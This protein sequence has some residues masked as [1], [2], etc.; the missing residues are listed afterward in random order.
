MKISNIMNIRHL[1]YFYDSAQFLSMS[2]AAKKNFVGQPAISKAIKS[3]EFDLGVTLVE[4]QNNRFNLTDEGLKAYQS[5]QKIFQSIDEFKDSLSEQNKYVGEVKFACQSS[6]AESQF[7]LN[8]IS[9]LEKQYPD[10]NPNLMLG[11]TDLVEKW[12]NEGIIDFG[13]VI[14]NRNF[15]NYKVF[16]VS[17]GNF[18]LVKSRKYKNNWKKEGVLCTEMTQEVGQLQKKFKN[19]NNVGLVKKMQIGSWSVIKNFVLHGLGVGFVPDYLVKKEIDN[20]L[21][22]YVEKKKFSVSYEIILIFLKN[23]YISSK[24][25]ETMSQFKLK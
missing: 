12:L 10:I 17:K 20:G 7:L 5:C 3:L 2:K 14:N 25:M 1:K 23:K 4:H 21:L 15:K 13:I 19:F 22:S 16:P 18:N 6:M 8:G 9:S 11:R 24:A